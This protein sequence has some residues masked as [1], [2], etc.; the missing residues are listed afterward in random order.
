MYIALFKFTL[1]NVPEGDV[2]V[3]KEAEP[4]TKPDKD[5]VFP[6]QMVWFVPAEIPAARFTV[7]LKVDTAGTQGP[8]PSGSFV[9]N[10]S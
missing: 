3:P 6:E 4:F 1:L 9:T 10:V 5:A 2:Q 8:A 7:T